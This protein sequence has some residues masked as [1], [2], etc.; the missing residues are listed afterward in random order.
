MLSKLMTSA[1]WLPGKRK[2]GRK[3]KKPADADSFAAPTELPSAPSSMDAAP[4]RAVADSARVTTSLDQHLEHEDVERD[5]SSK[6]SDEQLTNAKVAVHEN[7]SAAKD[8]PQTKT[9]SRDHNERRYDL[10][11]AGLAIALTALFS[12]VAGNVA[13]VIDLENSVSSTPSGTEAPKPEQAPSLDKVNLYAGRAAAG[14]G[15]WQRMLMSFQAS[16]DKPSCELYRKLASQTIQ[17]LNAIG[18][19]DTDLYNETTAYFNS[20]AA[21]SCANTGKALTAN[22]EAAKLEDAW[23]HVRVRALKLGW[24]D[25]CARENSLR[26]CAP[27]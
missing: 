16:K 3:A 11:I 20:L 2:H 15:R 12:F 5:L 9:P 23:Q 1:K 19:P 21:L 24:N 26:A 7:R 14:W 22:Y 10:A 17:E 4:L 13:D 25:Q 18:S 6:S 27:V 8:E